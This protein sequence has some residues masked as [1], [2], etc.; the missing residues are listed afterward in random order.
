VVG[1]TAREGATVA[2]YCSSIKGAVFVD[3]NYQVARTALGGRVVEE[4]NGMGMVDGVRWE[5]EKLF[6]TITP[7][8]MASN[9]YYV[10]S[11]RRNNGTIPCRS[12]K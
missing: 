4:R 6:C 12:K 7:R 10:S 5:Y 11:S 1:Q 8:L 3:I 9:R 2:T